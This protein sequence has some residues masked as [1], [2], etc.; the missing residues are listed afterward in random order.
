MNKFVYFLAL[1][2]ATLSA[3]T[4]DSTVHFNKDF[5]GSFDLAMDMGDMAGMFSDMGSEDSDDENLMSAFS[6]LMEDSSA[7]M[8][9]SLSKE[10]RE[11]GASNF[12]MGTNEMDQLVMSFDFDDLE[13]FARINEKIDKAE[14]EDA[15]MMGMMGGIG[16][17]NMTRKGKWLYIPLAQPGM[18]K[19]VFGDEDGDA[20]EEKGEAQAMAMMGESIRF[21]TTY[22]FDRKIKK[23]V[24]ELPIA[25]KENALIFECSLND[26]EEWSKGDRE[27][28]LA[29]KLK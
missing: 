25:R 8:M 18:M 10:L 23:I 17:S 13:T 3:C 27:H 24:S 22:S 4:I 1:T 28:I 20:A 6:T 9:D 12:K 29:V 15:K 2:F 16:N 26:L 11:V 5:S 14:N 7:H 21:R 19:D